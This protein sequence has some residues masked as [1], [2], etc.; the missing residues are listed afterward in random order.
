MAAHLCH[1]VSGAT[2]FGVKD[3]TFHYHQDRKAATNK[4]SMQIHVPTEASMDP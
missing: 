3:T 2:L 1:L 4:T